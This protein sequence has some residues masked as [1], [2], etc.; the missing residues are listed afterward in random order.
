VKTSTRRQGKDEHGGGMDLKEQ[1]SE[2]EDG[3]KA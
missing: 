2:D 3:T 1:F